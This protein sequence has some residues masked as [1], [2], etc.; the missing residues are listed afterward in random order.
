MPDYLEIVPVLATGLFAGAA[1][2]I[3]IGDQPARECIEPQA[4][5]EHFKEWYPRIAKPQASFAAIAAASSAWLAYKGGPTR[6]LNVTTAVLMGAMLPWTLVV[7]MPTNDALRFKKELSDSE[8]KTGLKRWS[9][10]HLVRT[11]ASIA[12]F[13]LAAFSLAASDKAEPQIV[14][15]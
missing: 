14:A 8:I 7:I 3:T 15:Y 4:A 13:G 12:A 10:L 5:R 9:K 11:V 2:G 6:S 1:L